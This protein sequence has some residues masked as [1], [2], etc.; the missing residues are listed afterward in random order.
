LE[1][2]LNEYTGSEEPRAGIRTR[3]IRVGKVSR[4]DS[5]IPYGKID[6]KKTEAG[7][8]EPQNIECRILNIEGRNSIDSNGFKR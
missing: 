3:R 8:S 7:K 5:S 6:F 2:S 1:V 4:V